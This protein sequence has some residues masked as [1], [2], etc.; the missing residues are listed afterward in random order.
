M[1]LGPIWVPRA[2]LAVSF[3]GL[4][5]ALFPG[6]KSTAQDPPVRSKPAPSTSH[7]SPDQ[8]QAALGSALLPVFPSDEMWGSN[9]AGNIP[10]SSQTFGFGATSL[11][12]KAG[13]KGGSMTI[14]S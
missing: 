1:G 13:G 3:A 6:P 2:G 5:C 12:R 14:G 9:G 7:L 8:S 11:S 10:A 4:G